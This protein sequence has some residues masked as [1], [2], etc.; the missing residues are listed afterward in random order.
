[1]AA[2]L[3]LATAFVDLSLKGMSAV[4]TGLNT[5][6]NK[7]Q[8]WVGPLA[9]NFQSAQSAVLG[10]VGAASPQ[11]MNTFTGS[12]RLVS[13]V[14][15]TALVPHIIEASRW[16]QKMAQYIRDMSPETKQQIA[17]WIKWGVVV[18][19]AVYAFTKLNSIISMV[20]AHP[21]AATFLAVAAAIMKVNAD[22]D[23]MIS[24][25][26]EAVD[27]MKRM[28]EGV[29][30]EGEYK[31]SAAAAIEEDESLSPEEKMKQAKAA[32]DRLTAEVKAQ[33]KEGINRGMF[34]ST[35]DYGLG[36]IGITNKTDELQQ[37][38]QQKLKEAGMLDN[39]IKRLGSGEKAKFTA[40]ADINK[41]KGND[42]LLMAGAGVGGGGGGAMSLESAFM[43]NAQAALAQDEISQKILQAQ[44]EGNDV[45]RKAAASQEQ[46]AQS[47]KRM[48]QP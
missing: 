1:M 36:S 10:F 26:N 4:M 43:A 18:M 38:V 13:A 27:V 40:A 7:L 29:Y 44:L 11:A 37:S 34:G 17:D 15:G 39:L 46:T 16:I 41:G 6:R 35:L 45:A 5:M 32:R 25:M 42:G 22:M 23:K 24:K 21:L 33:S 12:V 8:G 3:K 20:V 30:T 28:K 19:G 47:L 14:I 2:N 31:R 9:D 48:Q